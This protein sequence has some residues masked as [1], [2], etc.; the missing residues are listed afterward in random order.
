MD[1]L[2]TYAAPALV[3]ILTAAGAIIGIQFRDVDSSERRR[4]IWQWWLVVL[5]AIA[6]MAATSSAS[7]AG[8]PLEAILLAVFAA[9][10]AILAHVMWRRRVPNAEPRTRAIATAATTMAVVVVAG[11]TALTYGSGKG[12][13]QIEPL[14]QSSLANEAAPMPGFAP[15]QGPTI[16]DFDKW[17]N[18]IRA[19]AQQ[20][21]A[22]DVA[23]HA[24]RLGEL[25][26]QI[27]DAV[28]N[29]DKG[30]HAL[31]GT[32]YYEELRAILMKCHIQPTR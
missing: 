16:G 4:G 26:G 11:A 1:S 19:Q 29:N 8:N 2:V 9:A 30:S 12:C 20:V 28:R 32:Q 14:V 13:R 24:K 27:T 21:T 10:A 6:T 18:V 3:A 17:A 25:A 22:G 31:L 5:A 15:D 23:E 7:G